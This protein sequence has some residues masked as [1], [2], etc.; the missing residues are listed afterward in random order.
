MALTFRAYIKEAVVTD[1]PTGGFIADA[2]QDPGLP[3]AACWAE[4]RDS[5][6]PACRP[7]GHPGRALRMA[8]VRSCKGTRSLRA[9]KD[10]SALAK[11]RGATSE[12]ITNPTAEWQ[13]ARLT[14][15]LGFRSTPVPP[16]S[17]KLGK[18]R[19]EQRPPKRAPR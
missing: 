13:P 17:S 2:K 9:H 12:R 11:P 7:S 1:T 3:E 18:G 6:D 16:A 5:Q 10:G 14:Q 8:R 15:G 19:G 4:L